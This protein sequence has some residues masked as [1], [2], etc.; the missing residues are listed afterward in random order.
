MSA[1]SRLALSY[2]KKVCGSDIT[3]TKI[4][5]NLEK[6]GIRIFYE[7]KRENLDGCDLVCFSGAIPKDNFYINL[8]NEKG[9]DVAERS[10]ILGEISKFYKNVIAISGSHGKTTTTAMIGY[11]FEQAKLS[12]T[13]HVGGE[14]D[15][16]SGNLV[17]GEKNFFITEACEF[18]NSFL[19]LFPSVSVVTNVDREHL[20][21][22]KTFENEKLSFKK[23]IYQ[24]KNKSFVNSENA[25]LHSNNKTCFYDDVA[26]VKNLILNKNGKYSFDCYYEKD[27]VGKI[28]LNIYGKHNVSN[29][30][31]AVC[32]CKYFGIKNKIIVGA[33]SRFQNAKRRLEKIGKYKT[34]I[35]FSDYAHHPLEITSSLSA[36]K[37]AFSRDIICIF[38]PHTYSRTHILL[39]DFLRSFDN[40]NSLFLLPVYSAREKYNYYG[41]SNFLAKKFCEN[42]FEKL[43]GVYSKKQIL[44][45]IKNRNYKNKIILFL[46]AGDVGELPYELIKTK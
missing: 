18:R 20:D 25:F 16:F 23:F 4:T 33:L 5:D 10:E 11:V 21:F 39:K 6:S 7:E 17:V 42:N 29:A 37:D 36:L 1:I 46:G 3:R 38:Q 34:N 35:V 2:G 30:L 32:V 45:E 24:T 27:F 15:I 22:F 31:C 14:F 41:S 40:V 43:C 8:A 9:I 26:Q 44:Q 12:P 19:T 13:I 28:D